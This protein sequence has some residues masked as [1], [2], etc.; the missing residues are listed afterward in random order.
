MLG[1]TEGW[2]KSGDR[3]QD[4][5]IASLTQWTWVCANSGKQWRTR[6]PG[7][8]PHTCKTSPT[9]RLPFGMVHLLPLMNLNWLIIIT[10]LTLGV[11]LAVL[12]SMNFDRCLMTY[13]YLCNILQNS[14]TP[15]KNPLYFA[16]LSFLPPIPGKTNLYS[17][18]IVSPFPESHTIRIKAYGLLQNRLSFLVICI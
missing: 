10:K 6:K 11:T 12:H 2:M 1:K 17:I 14:F 3:G 18:C 13:I 15:P 8:L 7:V 5:W 16:Y 9:I 4:G